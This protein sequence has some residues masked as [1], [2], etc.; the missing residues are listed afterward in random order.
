MHILRG[1][2]AARRVT[3]LAARASQIAPKEP[4][5]K[6]IVAAVQRQGDT[7]LRGYARKWDRLGNQPLRVSSAQMRQSFRSTPRDLM[8]HV[9]R[10]EANIRSFAERQKPAEWRHTS[11]GVSVGQ[12]VRPLDSVGCYV[13]GGRYPLLSTLLMT[14]VPAQ[15]AGVPRICVVSPNPKPE[16]LAIA[17][18]LGVK[19]FYRL[20]GAQAIAALAYGTKSISRVDKIVGPGNAYVTV[21]KKLVAFDCAIDMLAGPTESVIVSHDGNPEWIAADLVA[22][23][24]HDPDA[25]PVFIT[26]SQRL[27]E[28]TLLALQVLTGTNPMAQ[29][30]L[31]NNGCILVARSRNQ[32]M[33]WANH[34]APEHLTVPVRD[35]ACVKNAG[36]VFVGDYSP[37]A[38]GDY[39][40]GPNHVLPTGGAA[41]FRGG[42]T[43]LDFIKLVTVQRLT[44]RGLHGLSPTIT[45]LAEMEGLEGHAQSIRTRF[46]NA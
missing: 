18:E 1:T 41:R 5:V 6:R 12:L 7:A 24:E 29:Q 19:E 23:A 26:C 31:K 11:G 22:Q 25:L 43:V 13:P 39:A 36:S 28:R 14:V 44:R 16:L 38:A 4:E 15:V 33:D 9:K 8:A 46:Q 40:T 10:A 2:V 27:A 37:Q 20:G 3:A 42:L 34:L 45:M 17:H 35:V 30:S 32:A 21:A